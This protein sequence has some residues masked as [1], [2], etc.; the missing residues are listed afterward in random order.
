MK[1]IRIALL[2]ILAA[3][4]A[5][6]LFA[7]QQQQGPPAAQRKSGS[8]MAVL[9]SDIQAPASHVISDD[10]FAALRTAKN[11][12]GPKP[13]PPKKHGLSL[14]EMSTVLSH[15]GQSTLLPK[16]SVIWTPDSVKD[17]IV[18]A[19]SG[20]TIP[21]QEFLTANRNWISTCEVDVKQ[22]CGEKPL[23][24]Q[25]LNSFKT[26]GVMIVAT[27][28]GGPV[29]VLPFSSSNVSKTPDATKR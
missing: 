11:G 13:M 7:Q 16:G 4:S 23:T 8:G 3:A 12:A 28:N 24:P 9:P 29:T 21:W 25:M 5:A 20:V 18:P 2:G 1:L 6:P 10:D 26:R 15:A 27:L 19:P 22:I 14:L 17:R